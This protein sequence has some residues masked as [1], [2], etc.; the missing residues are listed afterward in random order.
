MTFS[1]TQLEEARRALDAP[2]F[3]DVTGDAAV[4]FEFF[5]PKTAK[6]EETLWSAIE[7]LSSWESTRSSWKERWDAYV[8]APSSRLQVDAVFPGVVARRWPGVRVVI[9]SGSP[10]EAEGLPA[11]TRLLPKPFAPAALLRE[12]AGLLA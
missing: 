4:S 11:S 5:P 6:M 3:A 2:L 12:V 10:V 9:A 7:T 1:L 8:T